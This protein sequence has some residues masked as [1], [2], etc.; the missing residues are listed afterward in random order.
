MCWTKNVSLGFFIIGA[1]FTYF[2]YYKVDKLWSLSVLYF[3]IMQLIHYI[4][5]IVVDNCDHPL[6]KTMAYLNYVHIAFQPFI[7]L[8]GFYGLFKKYNIINPTQLINLKDIIK[9]SLIPCILFLLRL[10]PLKINGL[11]NHKLE[12][13]NCVWCGKTCSYSGKKHINF[14]LPLRIKP[15]YFTPG[16][17]FHFLFFFGPLMFYNNKTRLLNIFILITSFI[18]SFSLNLSPSESATT[19]CGISIVQLIVSL[20]LILVSKNNIK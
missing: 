10:F 5:Y 14:S 7:Y 9:L 12:T 3:T 1:L 8:L 18:P 13:N 2:S 15:F 16:Q 6:N 11:V 20:V 17:F 19:W 4:A